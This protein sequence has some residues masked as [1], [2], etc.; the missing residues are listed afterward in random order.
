MKLWIEIIILMKRS[1]VVHDV[2][3]WMQWIKN[4]VRKEI[5]KRISG[6][7]VKPQR[8]R[9]PHAETQEAE[10]FLRGRQPKL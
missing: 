1:G 4:S 6:F 7:L 10:T 5:Y 9:K 8:Q 3:K 2:R